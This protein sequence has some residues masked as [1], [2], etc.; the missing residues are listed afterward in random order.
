[1]SKGRPSKNDQRV[2]CGWLVNKNPVISNSSPL[3]D[4]FTG[5]GYNLAFAATG[6]TP[7]YKWSVVEGSLPANLILN[8]ETGLLSG[9]LAAAGAFNFRFK[10]KDTFNR[11]SQKAF[12]LYLQIF[13]VTG[14]GTDFGLVAIGTSRARSLVVKNEGGKLATVSLANTGSAAFTLPSTP[15]VLDPGGSRSVDVTFT[16]LNTNQGIFFRALIAV[17]IP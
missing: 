11:S 14:G 5:Q 7:P 13:P 4:G 6:G 8:P 16:P 17:S 2:R 12:T 10:V 9:G 1:P 3:P 15:F